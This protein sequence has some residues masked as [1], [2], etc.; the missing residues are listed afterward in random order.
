MNAHGDRCA[1]AYVFLCIGCLIERAFPAVIARAAD[2]MRPLIYRDGALPSQCLFCR[3]PRLMVSQSLSCHGH[4]VL[5]ATPPTVVPPLSSRRIWRADNIADAFLSRRVLVLGRAPD[6]SA[7]PGRAAA[8]LGLSPPARGRCIEDCGRACASIFSPAR[9]L[10]HA[11]PA[12][13][14]HATRSD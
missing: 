13:A 11:L 12:A 3:Q 4:D 1:A 14:A 2:N 6:A 8:R 7:P 5:P 10:H 9:L